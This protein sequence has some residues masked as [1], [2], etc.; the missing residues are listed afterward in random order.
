MY[1]SLVKRIIDVVLS[2]CGILILWP[3]L[4]IVAALIKIEDPG[5]AFFRQTRSGLHRQPFT[6]VKFRTMKT[7]TPSDLPTGELPDAERC[8]TRAGR[9]LRKTS[10]D[11]LP[12]LFQILTGKMSIVGPRPVIC[13][14]TDLLDER[15]RY[16]AND[17]RPGLTGWAQINGRDRLSAKEKA[18]YD[19]E[20][21]QYMSFRF[22]CRCFFG[23]FGRM[24]DTT[25]P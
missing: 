18:R 23:T 6:L 8:F 25:V 4:L 5:P 11:E 13:R 22:D 16:G 9:F 19:G 15:D 14:E 17:V 24:I 20:Y 21:V 7:D 3:L 1:Q 10:L 2:L 12:Q